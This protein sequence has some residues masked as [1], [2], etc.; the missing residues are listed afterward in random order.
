MKTPQMFE[1]ITTPLSDI[2]F[3]LYKIVLV[4]DRETHIKRMIL[5]NLGT[6]QIESDDSMEPYY[7]LGAEVI[8]VSS[9]SVEDA[10][11]KV[12]DIL[13]KKKGE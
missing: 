10:A 2:K 11:K 1:I 12:I 7:H 6:E 9:I 5:D 3:E 8:D 13:N 4:C